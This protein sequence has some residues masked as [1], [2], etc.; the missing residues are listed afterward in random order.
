MTEAV[1]QRPAAKRELAPGR[2][3]RANARPPPLATTF[4][5][6]ACD[7]AH[8]PKATEIGVQQVSSYPGYS[9]RTSR[10][11][12]GSKSPSMRSFRA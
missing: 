8:W 1:G 3:T 10:I 2:I 7:V 6:Q 11:R 5:R 12:E 4:V 9:G